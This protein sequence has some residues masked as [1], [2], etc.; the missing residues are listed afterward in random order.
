MKGFVFF[1]LAASV[2]AVAFWSYEH[3][4]DAEAQAR[5][6]VVA[7]GTAVAQGAQAVSKAAASK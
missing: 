7:A 1:V 2:G 5:R 3:P 6:G 4:K